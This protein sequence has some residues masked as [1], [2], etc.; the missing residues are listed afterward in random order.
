MPQPQLAADGVG[1]LTAGAAEH[2][3]Y[4]VAHEDAEDHEHRLVLGRL[5]VGPVVGRRRGTMH[6]HSRNPQSESGAD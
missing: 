1:V 4:V 6:H 2:R 3:L 5:E